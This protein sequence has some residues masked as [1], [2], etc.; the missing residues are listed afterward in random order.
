MAVEIGRRTRVVAERSRTEENA[1]GAGS[2]RHEA[3]DSNGGL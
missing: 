3:A 1:R 2:D